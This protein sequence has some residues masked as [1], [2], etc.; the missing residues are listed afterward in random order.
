M[1]NTLAYYTLYELADYYIEIKEKR[2]YYKNKN[3]QL[4][5]VI[6]DIFYRTTLSSFNKAKL[7]DGIYIIDKEVNERY[8]SLTKYRSHLYAL[9]FINKREKRL[10]PP[11]RYFDAWKRARI[12]VHGH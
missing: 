3:H 6:A 8:E 10:Y 2:S 1:K 9:L 7:V 12:K 11:Q 4:L 5:A